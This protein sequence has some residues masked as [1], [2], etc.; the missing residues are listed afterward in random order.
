[1]KYLSIDI[2]TTGLDPEKCDVLE[3]AF[4]IE[5]TENKL[6][7]EYC[8]TLHLFL[9][10]DF[11]NFEPKALEMNSETMDIIKKLKE[12]QHYSLCKPGEITEKINS[13]LFENNIDTITLAGA[14]LEGFDMKFLS[15]FLTK[16]T[17]LR[18]NRRAI[19]PA[20]YFVD[21]AKDEKLPSL[22]ECKKRAGIEG[23]VAHNA[24]DDAWDVIQ[25]LR[26]QY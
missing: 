4:I 11:Y 2:E 3:I 25:V 23:D 6:P 15:R 17:L 26:T 16:L 1:M 19:E 20:H 10:N 7:R 14:N 18:F 21:W 9:D 5:D 24:L 12:K 8:P 22:Q 13:F